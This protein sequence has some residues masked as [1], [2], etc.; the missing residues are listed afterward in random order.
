MKKVTIY[1]HRNSQYKRHAKL[2]WR[3]DQNFG[4]KIR[5][6]KKKN[7]GKVLAVS[8]LRDLNEMHKMSAK[9]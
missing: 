8:F 3:H 6:T 1:V 5:L 9:Q 7:N 2:C 4:S